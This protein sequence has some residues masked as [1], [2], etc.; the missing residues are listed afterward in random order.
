MRTI[1]L[2][3]HEFPVLFDFLQREVETWKAERI[4]PL[5]DHPAEFWALNNLF[6]VMEPVVGEVFRGDYEAV[7]DSARAAVMQQCDPEGTFPIGARQ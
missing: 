6:C 4:A 1:T 3:D 5:L 2:E 7:I